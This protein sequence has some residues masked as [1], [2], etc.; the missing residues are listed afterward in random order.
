MLGR[1]I[2]NEIKEASIKICLHR[3]GYL[4][5]AYMAKTCMK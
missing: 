2:S 4:T 3:T 1:D 5:I